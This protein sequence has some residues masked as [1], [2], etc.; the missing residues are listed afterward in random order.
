MFNFSTQRL[1]LVGVQ[2]VCACVSC[3]RLTAAI[4]HRRAGWQGDLLELWGNYGNGGLVYPRLCQVENK[5]LMCLMSCASAVVVTETEWTTQ[6][7]LWQQSQIWLCVCVWE[8]RSIVFQQYDLS[9]FSQHESQHWMLTLIDIVLLQ[10]VD[11]I[12]KKNTLP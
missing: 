11:K 6:W 3:G 9:L 4:Y 1:S 10:R 8:A 2:Y 5:K 12:W 7:L